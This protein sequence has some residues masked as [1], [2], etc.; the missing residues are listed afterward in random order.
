MNQ[1]AL[2]FIKIGGSLI[3]HKDRAYS[4]NQEA[5][6]LVVQEIKKAQDYPAKIILGHGSGS[7]GHV[8]A[9]KYQT[10]KG[11]LNEE[12]YWGIAEVAQAASELHQLVMRELLEFGV[13]AF[14]FPP[15]AFL[16]SR[17]HQLDSL[18]LDSL[19][20]A[21]EIDL[22]PVV[23]GDQI[24]DRAVGCTIFSTEQVL[25]SLALALKKQGYEIKQMIQCGQTNGVYDEAGQTIPL[26]TP[27]NFSEYQKSI[28]D[29]AEVDVT[30]GMLHKVKQSLALAEQGIESLIIDG[31]EHGSLSQAIAGKEVV[32]T[33]IKV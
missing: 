6:E 2:T 25:T 14:S 7:Y 30:G 20:K 21:L 5:L 3:T 11:I 31:I 1:S 9:Q 27:K 26:I 4:V 28:A 32:G 24:L 29:S 17:D 23:Y 10:Q 33:K 18:Y 22:L 19:K 15:H 16:T 13:R 12:S 8:A